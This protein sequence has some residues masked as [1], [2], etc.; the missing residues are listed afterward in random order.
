MNMTLQAHSAAMPTLAKTIFVPEAAAHANTNNAFFSS[1]GIKALRRFNGALCRVAPGAAAALARRLIATPPRHAPRAWE[2]QLLERADHCALTVGAHTIPVYSWGRGRTVLLVHSWGGR[3][4][5][6]GRF[7]QPLV[8]AGFRPVAFDLPAHGLGA[9]GETDMVDCAAAIGAV[10]R[11]IG[12]I[13][14]TIAHSFGVMATLLAAREHGLAAPNLVTIGAFEH[15]RW[16]I[17]A[18]QHH[19]G[20]SDQVAQRIRDNFEARHAHRVSFDRL[21]VVEMLREARCNALVIHDRH[22]REVPY[23]HSHSL[24]AVGRHIQAFPTVGLG[25]RRILADRAV[26]DKSVAWLEARAI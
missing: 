20:L 9:T 10:K 12:P 13:H 6:M 4:M 22:D 2:T 5:Q 26:I 18:A 7:V 1:S 25:H 8:E 23:A 24:R 16:F 3:A 17:D 19:L 11:G 15:C 14:G 21:S